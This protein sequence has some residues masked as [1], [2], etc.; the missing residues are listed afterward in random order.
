M[1][2]CFRFIRLRRHSADSSCYG[3]NES[4]SFTAVNN[5]VGC[6]Y[7]VFDSKSKGQRLITEMTVELFKCLI[8]LPI[9]SKLFD[10]F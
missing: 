9:C 1:E 5:V 6:L 3:V 2:M 4:Y 8:H 7:G 10:G